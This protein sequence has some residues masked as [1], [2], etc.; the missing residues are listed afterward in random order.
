[1]DEVHF[2][3]ADGVHHAARFRIA[4]EADEEDDVIA[5]RLV[6]TATHLKRRDGRVL[7]S[8]TAPQCGAGRPPYPFALG[9]EGTRRVARSNEASMESRG[10]VCWENAYAGTSFTRSIIIAM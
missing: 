8:R 2:S 6:D 9:V 5:T 4:T 3:A 7:A 1:M 10:A